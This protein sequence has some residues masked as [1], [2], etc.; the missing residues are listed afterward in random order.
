MTLKPKELK[1]DMFKTRLE[2]FELMYQVKTSQCNK[3]KKAFNSRIKA[4]QRLHY[5]QFRQLTRL[6]EQEQQKQ[7]DTPPHL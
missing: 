1:E 4:L 5:W 2:I 3:E 7:E 6:E